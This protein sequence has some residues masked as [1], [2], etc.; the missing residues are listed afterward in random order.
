[1]TDVAEIARKLSKAQ[2]AYLL[3]HDGSEYHHPQH[4][5]TAHWAREHGYTQTV[6]HLP[7]GRSIPWNDLPAK[8]RFAGKFSLGGRVLTPLGIAVR[9]YLKGQED[10]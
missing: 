7:D 3:A 5:Q 8:V 6:V 1:M 10:E 2:R 9:D 4:G